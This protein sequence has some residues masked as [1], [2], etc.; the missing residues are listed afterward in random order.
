M[1][2]PYASDKDKTQIWDK[3]KKS[4]D[5]FQYLIEQIF[6][7][8]E[9]E[10]WIQRILDRYEP[11]NKSRYTEVNKIDWEIQKLYGLVDEVWPNDREIFTQQLLNYTP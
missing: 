3:K 4:K 8:T 11:S 1:S 6:I 2:N 10:L 9:E 7:I 5:V